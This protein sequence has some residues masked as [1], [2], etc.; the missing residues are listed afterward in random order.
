MD[1]TIVQL[2]QQ[3]NLPTET[4]SPQKVFSSLRVIQGEISLK[5]YK[6]FSE[7]IPNIGDFA[8][9]FDETIQKKQT[10]ENR[11]EALRKMSSKDRDNRTLLQQLEKE[12]LRLKLTTNDDTSMYKNLN[13]L[14]P[15]LPKGVGFEIRLSDGSIFTGNL[16][17]EYLIDP[18]ESIFLNY[19]EHLPDQWNVLGIMDFAENAETETSTGD[20]ITILSVCMKQIS[21]MFLNS[22]SQATI[23]PLLIYRD[24]S[25]Q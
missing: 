25:V 16:K 1:D 7:L 5:N 17:S 11:I 13:I 18:E 22:I 12:L 9:L 20:P 2:L 10:L 21:R 4:I 8:I 19:G 6:L 23:I 14:L 24:L 15:F 3:L